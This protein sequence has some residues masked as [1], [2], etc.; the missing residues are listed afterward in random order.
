L[1]APG[2]VIAAKPVDFVCNSLRI[3]LARIVIRL[4]LEMMPKINV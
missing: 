2:L 4:G 3:A 1:A